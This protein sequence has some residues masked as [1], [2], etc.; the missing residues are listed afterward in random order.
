MKVLYS[1]GVWNGY[2]TKCH[3]VIHSCR[4]HLRQRYFII[5]YI[6]QMDKYIDAFASFLFFPFFDFICDFLGFDPPPPP[7]P[8][9]IWFGLTPIKTKHAA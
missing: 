6:Q 8:P 4:F 9:P 1:R 5:Y 3:A 2:Q 7:P